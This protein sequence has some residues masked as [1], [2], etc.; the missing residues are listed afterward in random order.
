MYKQDNKYRKQCFSCV[1]YCVNSLV[2]AYTS[3]D[4]FMFMLLL[5][6]IVNIMKTFPYV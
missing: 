2:C 1:Y 3:T 6:A 4:M 5:L